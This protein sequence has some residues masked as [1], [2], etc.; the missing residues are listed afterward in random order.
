ML[1]PKILNAIRKDTFDYAGGAGGFIDKYC[2]PF[3]RGRLFSTLEKDLQQ[4]DNIKKIFWGF[5]GIFNYQKKF[6]R[7]FRLL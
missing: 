5:W 1:V 6:T 4:Y 7:R 3:V 2:F